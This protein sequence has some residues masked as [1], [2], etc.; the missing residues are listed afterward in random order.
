VIAAAA[1]T[2]VGVF[3]ALPGMAAGPNWRLPLLGSVAQWW[4]WGLVARLIVAI[5]GLLPSSDR[6]L[7][8]RILL[9]ALLSFPITGVY[10][11]VYAAILAL[12]GRESWQTALSPQ[13]LGAVL[14]GGMFL[15]SW[16]VYWLIVGGWQAYQYYRRYLSTELR[17]ERLERRFTEARLNV[18]RMQLDPHFLF[19]AL[20]T[21]SSQVERDPRLARA[22]IE[23]LGDLLRMSLETRDKQ[24]IPLVEELAFLDHY[25]AIQRIRFGDHLKIEI[26]VDP[27]VKYVLVPSLLL[28]PLVE[29]AIR[30]GLSPRSS[31][32]TIVIS[33]RRVSG[34]LEIR[35]L[36]D[37]VGLPIGWALGT[38]PGL[39]LTSTRDRIA[40]LHAGGSSHFGV[41]RLPGGGTEVEIRLPMTAGEEELDHVVPA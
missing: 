38:S 3:F 23:H 41:R 24:E 34:Q 25:L 2:A 7:A 21:I 33:A 39:G 18:L 28:Q 11:Y 36:D 20:N 5:D 19:N 9:H 1:W 31:G 40:G 10:F 26:R 12:F 29:N 16:L 37:G 8:R 13:M 14:R 17:M 35:V 6:Q 4:A 15:W 27:D 32:G 22:M 30:H